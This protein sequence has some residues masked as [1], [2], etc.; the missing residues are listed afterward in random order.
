MNKYFFIIV[1][2]AAVLLYVSFNYWRSQS[3]IDS[4][5]YVSSNNASESVEV[6]G[7]NPNLLEEGN[8]TNAEVLEGPYHLE[9]STLD[10]VPTEPQVHRIAQN[11]QVIMKITTA[12]D[13]AL[14]I[15]GYDLHAHTQAGQMQELRFVAEHAGR[16]EVELHKSDRL[17]GVLEIFP[18]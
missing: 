4:E 6:S 7:S 11:S 2:L 17:I 13:E 15:H 18:D 10:G 14:H 1:I 5:P 12:Q 16:F 3:A 8:H 9:Y